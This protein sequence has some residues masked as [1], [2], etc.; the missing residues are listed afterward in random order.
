MAIGTTHLPAYL[1]LLIAH[2]RIAIIQFVTPKTFAKVVVF[3]M[4]LE[5][6]SPSWS[7]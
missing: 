6:C 7:I 1:F 5:K 4:L 3:Q 2:F